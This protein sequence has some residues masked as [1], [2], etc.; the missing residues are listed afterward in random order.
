[1]DIEI[2][3]LEL[4]L[5]YSRENAGASLHRRFTHT[6]IVIDIH[7]DECGFL[8]VKARACLFYG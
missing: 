8:R 1:M 6:Y 7:R 3:G 2:G 4:R 5:L